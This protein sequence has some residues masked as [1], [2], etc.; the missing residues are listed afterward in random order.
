MC[1]LAEYLEKVLF[2]SGV[3]V[4]TGENNPPE[5]DT[6]QSVTTRG[7]ETTTSIFSTGPYISGVTGLFNKELHVGD[8][9]SNSHAFN[10]EKGNGLYDTD[11]VLKPFGNPAGFNSSYWMTVSKQAYSGFITMVTI[12]I[13]I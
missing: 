4:L 11:I 10:F 7:N 2:V 9:G 5:A 8:V 6:L 1:R 13:F 3:P 12:V